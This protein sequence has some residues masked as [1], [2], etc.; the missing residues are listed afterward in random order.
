MSHRTNIPPH[1]SPCTGSGNTEYRDS[2][3]SGHGPRGGP[4]GSR[5]VRVAVSPPAPP[6]PVPGEGVPV[7]VDGGVPGIGPPVSLPSPRL[8]RVIQ[9]AKRE[10]GRIVSRY[11]SGVP[12]LGPRSLDLALEP[13]REP[14][15]YR[16]TYEDLLPSMP[17][18]CPY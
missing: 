4:G 16:V 15:H 11:S 1:C 5:G 2:S 18:E 12:S 13:V 14:G 9:E 17:E 8:R 6:V 3:G 7:G 10:L